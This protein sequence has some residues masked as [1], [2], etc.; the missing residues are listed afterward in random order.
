MFR[1][2]GNAGESEESA[3]SVKG[4]GNWEER[5]RTNLGHNWVKKRGVA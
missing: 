2:H 4:C 5:F 1:S 3:R